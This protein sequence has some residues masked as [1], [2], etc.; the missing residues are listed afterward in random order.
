MVPNSRSFQRDPF[1]LSPFLARARE[2]A[3]LVH[4]SLPTASVYLPP[5]ETGSRT[6]VISRTVELVQVNFL[7][8]DTRARL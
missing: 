3:V 5:A 2:A 8:K 7:P 4:M 6:P 1:L